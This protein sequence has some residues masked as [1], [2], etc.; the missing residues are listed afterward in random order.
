[1]KSPWYL[2]SS[3]IGAWLHHFLIWMPGKTG[4]KLRYFIYKKLFA[5]CGKKVFI[6]TGCHI[7]E[8]KNISLGNN[9]FIG[10]YNQIYASGTGEEKIEIED[11]VTLTSNIIIN[12]DCGG[13]IK[14]GKHVAIGPNTIVR[15]S[16]HKFGDSHIPFQLQ[17]HESGKIIIEE[18]VWVGAHCVILPNVKIGK[19]S[20]IAAGAV[21]TKD[22]DAYTIVG[23][24]PAKKI[25]TRKEEPNYVGENVF[26]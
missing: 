11:H 15:A 20:V 1:M 2:I 21:V 6:E 4:Y 17:G 13:H 25:G 23:G 8:F 18:D 26:S 9:V 3:E 7:R 12:A 24:V 10:M 14:I 19:G 5:G 22:V 16:N